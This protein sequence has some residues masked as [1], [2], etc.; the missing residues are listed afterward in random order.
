MADPAFA[1]KHSFHD[2]RWIATEDAE[3]E[4][5]HDPRSWDISRGSLICQMRDGPSANA[6]LIAAAPDLLAALESVEVELGRLLAS[7]TLD[8][9]DAPFHAVRKAR[10][11][12][13]AAI[14][15]AKGIT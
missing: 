7:R 8:S 4:H 11:N 5:G 1:G 3:V 12:I 9:T 15:R 10:D 6:R 14:A 2:H 13:T